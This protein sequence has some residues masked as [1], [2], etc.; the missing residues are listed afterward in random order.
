MFCDELSPGFFLQTPMGLKGLG[1]GAWGLG[2]R[3][4]GLETLHAVYAPLWGSKC[5]DT[6]PHAHKLQLLGAMWGP[7]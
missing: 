4:W 5:I 6:I 2:F 7:T 1:S 3:V